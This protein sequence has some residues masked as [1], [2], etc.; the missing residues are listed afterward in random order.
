MKNL[1]EDKEQEQTFKELI[2]IIE[3]NEEDKSENKGKIDLLSLYKINND[4]IGWI[5]IENTSLN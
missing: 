3:N 5:R 4:L 2:E 1:R